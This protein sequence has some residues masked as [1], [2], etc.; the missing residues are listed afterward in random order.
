MDK[1]LKQ[2]EQDIDSVEIPSNLVELQEFTQILFEKILSG[3]E[4]LVNLY[5]QA[6]KTYNN[7][8]CFPAMTIIDNLKNLKNMATK[9]A[10]KA[11]K[12]EPAKKAAP[13]KAAT[14]KAPV[15]K[16]APAKKPV[17]K[18]EPVEGKKISQKEQVIELANQGLTALEIA[19]E[20]GIN[21]NNVRWYFS[22][23][24]LGAKKEA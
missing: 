18:S 10:K 17:V 24:K 12:K 13:K 14:K 1:L 21:I 6:A 11:T 8:V 5:N 7:Q 23:L 22:K 4:N 19:E 20:T 9:T 16:A 2:L 15:K 3:Q